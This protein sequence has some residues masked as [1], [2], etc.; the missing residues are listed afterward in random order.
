MTDPVQTPP[1]WRDQRRAERAARRGARDAGRGQSGAFIG[2]FVLIAVGVIFLIQQ[3]GVDL[4]NNWWALFIL[5]PA[6]GAF[7]RGFSAYRANG[8]RLD[9]AAVTAFAGALLF[10]TLTVIFLTGADWSVVW[11]ILVIIIGLG[12]LGRGLIRSS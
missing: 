8:N 4:P 3:L 5:I 7:A 6:A 2:G 11:P 10:V 12:V 1:D 9:S